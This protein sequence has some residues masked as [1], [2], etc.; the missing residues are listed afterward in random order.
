MG[1]LTEV[2]AAIRFAISTGKLS[3]KQQFWALDSLVYTDLHHGSDPLI[4]RNLSEMETLVNDN[5]LGDEKK[6]S[7]YIK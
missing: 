1:V 3:F 6:T 7:L 4:L 5:N 2:L